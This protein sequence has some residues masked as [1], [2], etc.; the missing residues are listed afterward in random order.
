V[1][2]GRQATR[3][4]VTEEDA[5]IE[6]PESMMPVTGHVQSRAGAARNMGAGKGLRGERRRSLLIGGAAVVYFI[7]ALE[8]V[9]MISPFA[10]FF[11][12]V[13]NPILL[14]LN[15]SAATRWL[16]AFFLPHMVV[17]TTSLLLALRVL[18]SVLFI[19]GSLVFLVCAGQVYLGKL[20]KWGVAHRGFYALMRHPQYSALVMAGLGLAILWPRFLTLMFLAVMAF[21]YYLL[22]KDEERRMLRQH[23][24]TYQAYLER[25]G[26]FW[27]RLGR[28][29]AAAKPVKWQAA[30]LLLGGLVGGAAALGFGLRAYTV[31]H[32]PLARVDGVDVVSIIP[33]DLPT[34]VD[35]VQGVR[36]DP[37]AANKLREMRTS[38]HSRILAYVMPVDY[39]MQG[40]IADT[41]PD[42]KL[43]RHHQTLAMIANYVLHPIGHL[44]G[45]HMHHA[46][47]TPMQH[48]PEMYNSP[49]MRRRIVFLEVRGNH[50]LTT[51][52]DDFA[53]NNQR[54]PRFFV[55][56]HLHTNEVLQVRATPHGTGWGTVPTPMF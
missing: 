41:G 39:V 42:W 44:Q 29:P 16:A 26:M 19:G 37:V 40:M 15:Q 34:A 52:R 43:F 51:A 7:A 11:Y 38:G 2:R 3:L 24:H 32:L 31:A 21:L 36:D 9:I 49:M 47:A 45:G 23:G 13:F 46:M 1:P 20:L 14:G 8:V 54:L 6:G 33:A 53:I 4:H 22:A 28:G 35:L 50:P 17:P 55:D 25:T 56:V 18:G 48:G 27:P 12:S 30:L 5:L 10:F